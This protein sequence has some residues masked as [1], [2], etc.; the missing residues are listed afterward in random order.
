MSKSSQCAVR[1][2]IP[3][4]R[5]AAVRRTFFKFFKPS[6][7]NPIQFIICFVQ[8][9]E[10]HCKMINKLFY[11]LI[12]FGNEKDTIHFSI[13]RNTKWT[14]TPG[15]KH[16]TTT[17]YLTTFNVSENMLMHYLFFLNVKICYKKFGKTFRFP[18]C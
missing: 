18:R 6:W 7:T 3:D 1:K 5:T 17:T 10:I 2:R 11:F 12:D 15:L 13:I 9:N 14:Q 8:N 16:Y 4:E